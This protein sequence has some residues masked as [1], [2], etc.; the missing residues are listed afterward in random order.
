MPYTSSGIFFCRS[1]KLIWSSSNFNGIGLWLHKLISTDKATVLILISCCNNILWLMCIN[2][3]NGF[4][5]CQKKSTVHYL[6]YPFHCIKYP[7][8]ILWDDPNM[9][10]GNWCEYQTKRPEWVSICAHVE[11]QIAIELRSEWA[12]IQFYA[13]CL[14]VLLMT[15]WSFQLARCIY[16][17]D[18][19]GM[20]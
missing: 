4:I 9:I 6:L 1:T 15:L 17:M 18:L 13:A 10:D 5:F 2:L 20:N 12:K 14:V 7:N 16:Q 3:T 8:K 11:R 19:K